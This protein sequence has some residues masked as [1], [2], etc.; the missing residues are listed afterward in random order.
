MRP[1]PRWTA[2][3]HDPGDPVALGLMLLR[4]DASAGQ[5]VSTARA[6]PR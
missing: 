6:Q 5:A 3:V 1:R 2:R 4:S